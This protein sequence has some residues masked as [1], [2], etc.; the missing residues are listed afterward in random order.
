MF[1]G[2]LIS[3][4]A[5]A[6]L[7]VVHEFGHYI[8][9]RMFGVHVEKFVIGMGKPFISKT[10]NGTEYG[11]APF[12]IG[13]YCKLK[14]ERGTVLEAEKSMVSGAIEKDEKAKEPSLSAKEIEELKTAD[15]SYFSKNFW[16]K[17]VILASGSVFNLIF[18]FVLLWISTFFFLELPMEKFYV[19]N[20]IEN[21]AAANAG[22]KADD[23]IKGYIN[24][25]G[26]SVYTKMTL[27]GIGDLRDRGI[28]SFIVATKDVER[29]VTMEPKLITLA[30]GEEVLSFG[31]D[32]A[33]NR[34]PNLAESVSAAGV[35][36]VELFK[37][38]YDGFKTL[39]NNNTGIPTKDLVAGPIGIVTLAGE[40]GANAI[41]GDTATGSQMVHK[42][43]IRDFVVLW[44]LISMNLGVVNLLP[45]P[46]LDGGHILGEALTKVRKKNKLFKI[47]FDFYSW[48]GLAALLA[49]MLF[50]TINDIVRIIF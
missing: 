33:K 13:G 27:S 30:T 37:M 44:V 39:A 26:E 8:T 19:N 45:I 43:Y 49:L 24:E 6:V 11:I 7:I 46:P 5:F 1:F 47:A 48:A 10:V 50:A 17:F 41:S 29:V 34:V 12:P 20:V 35:M 23:E 15:D 21:S 22:I 14:G 31:I 4:M 9:A 42:G 28:R 32:G 40:Q 18:A 38:F 16:Q 25:S 2:V 36:Y 3:I